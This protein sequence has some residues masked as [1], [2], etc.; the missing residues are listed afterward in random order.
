MSL[1]LP[2]LSLL[3]LQLRWI[4][5]LPLPL[6]P[7]P[8]PP[9]RPSLPRR[10][11][12][13]LVSPLPFLLLLPLLLSQLWRTLAPTLRACWRSLSS[14]RRPPRLLFLQLQTRPCLLLL[15]LWVLLLCLRLAALPL[16]RRPLLLR[17]RLPLRPTL[18]LPSPQPKLWLLNR[19]SLQLSSPSLL[20][21]LRPLILLLRRW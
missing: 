18:L 10:P 11:P 7:L 9:L 20:L 1:Q 16:S 2:P 19:P 17:R 14:L 5:P 15:L 4:L 8:L 13:T 6:L 3:I 12:R 21:P